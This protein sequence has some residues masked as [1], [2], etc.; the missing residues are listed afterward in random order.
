MGCVFHA[1]LRGSACCSGFSCGVSA[2]MGLEGICAQLVELLMDSGWGD[3][4]STPLLSCCDSSPSPSR[5]ST[6]STSC[7]AV[8]WLAFLYPAP[9][10]NAR[11]PRAICIGDKLKRGW[12]CG[13]GNVSRAR[14]WCGVPLSGVRFPQQR[15]GKG[16]HSSLAWLCPGRV[17]TG[18][19]SA[20]K[21]RGS[22]C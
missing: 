17:Q 3:C 16:R 6:S 20:Q 9:A 21:S 2:S 5:L 11:F 10:D 8:P 4:P 15:P 19:C 18:V 12:V 13:R 22:G 1:W 14:T 7:P